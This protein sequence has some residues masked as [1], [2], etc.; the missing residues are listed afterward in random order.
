M[1]FIKNLQRTC[2]VCGNIHNFQKI[3][4]T[5]GI[6]MRDLDTRLP[7]LSRNM[8]H[9]FMEKCPKCGAEIIHEGGCNICKNCGWTKCE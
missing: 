8:M 7:G 6:G 4:E 5:E 3:V 1:A 2:A 9:L